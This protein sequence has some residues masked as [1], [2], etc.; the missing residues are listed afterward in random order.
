MYKKRS[1][2]LV[3]VIE[4]EADISGFASIMLEM[5]GFTVLK[6]DT[7]ERGLEL[8]YQNKCA[9]VLLDLRLR[10]RDGWSVLKEMKGNT[11]L[12]DIPVIMFTSS[13]DIDSQNRALKMGAVDY[14]V[15]PI[16][17]A[18]MMKSI[19]RV[20]KKRAHH[21]SKASGLSI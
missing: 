7:G 6:A 11:N 15:K 4:D 16:S 18:S 5:E 8:V 9:L 1:K 10:L 19:N 20:L 14:L 13:A 3:L 2:G 21:N 12:S 17:A